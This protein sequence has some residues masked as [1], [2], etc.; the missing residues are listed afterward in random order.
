MVQIMVLCIPGKELGRRAHMTR[1]RR[2]PFWFYPA[3]KAPAHCGF[4]STRLGCAQAHPHAGHVGS[5]AETPR[6]T[7]V[8]P[9][10]GPP[11]GE[12]AAAVPPSRPSAEAGLRQTRF[13]EP[14]LRASPSARGAR[15]VASLRAPCRCRQAPDT[16]TRPGQGDPHIPRPPADT[17]LPG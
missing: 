13:L 6:L 2:A 10:G 5:E 3:S 16:T 14:F 12:G 7:Q 11:P 9:H 4:D 1:H 15:P 8:P 17:G